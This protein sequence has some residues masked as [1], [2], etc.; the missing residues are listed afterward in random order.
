MWRTMALC[1]LAVV[2]TMFAA[3]NATAQ[4]AQRRASPV[5]VMQIPTNAVIHKMID[6]SPTATPLGFGGTWFTDTDYPAIAMRQGHM[7]Q[8]IYKVLVSAVGTATKCSVTKSSGWSELDE[9]TCSVVLRRARFS[10]AIDKDGKAVD[11]QYSSSITWRIP[12]D[13]DPPNQ[14]PAYPQGYFLKH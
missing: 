14:V 7:G 2:S 5:D 4:S 1:G 9:A 8:V 12:R 10:P 3:T 6:E 11:S 13:L